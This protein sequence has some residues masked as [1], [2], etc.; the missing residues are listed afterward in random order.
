MSNEVVR[1]LPDLT[2]A[3]ADAL[4]PILPNGISV[5]ADDRHLIVQ[6]RHG[7]DWLPVVDNVEGNVG[8]WSTDEAIEIAVNNCINVLQDVVTEHLAEP[9][10]H[11]PGAPRSEFAGY[12]VEVR[13]GIL[14]IWFGRRDAPLFPIIRIG[15]T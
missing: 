1:D 13:A 15:L 8:E 5:S 2:Q 3:L 7:Y 12:G 6:T 11:P 9:W 10:P 4:R 14:S